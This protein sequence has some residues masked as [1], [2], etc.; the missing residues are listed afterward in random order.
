MQ[1]SLLS[2][3]EKQRLDRFMKSVARLSKKTTLS[4]GNSFLMRQQMKAI[5]QIFGV[6]RPN[7][8]LI[9]KALG[10]MRSIWPFK[11]RRLRELVNERRPRQ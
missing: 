3:K 4:K 9:G 8:V 2:S 1:K 10:I 6:V 7:K 11:E 5:L